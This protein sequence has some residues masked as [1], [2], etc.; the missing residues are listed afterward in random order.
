M[1]QCCFV[2]SACNFVLAYDLV[3]AVDAPAS[4]SVGLCGA[5]EERT[6]ARASY[7]YVG[8]NRVFS[9]VSA[10]RLVSLAESFISLALLLDCHA[11]VHRGDLR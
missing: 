9:G 4:R 5:A 3:R 6:M 11:D 10:S 1:E 8:R 7:A 2:S